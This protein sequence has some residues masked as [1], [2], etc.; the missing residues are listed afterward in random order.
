MDKY[1]HLV[2]CVFCACSMTEQIKIIITRKCVETSLPS[3]SR[4][5]FCHCSIVSKSIMNINVSVIPLLSGILD[6]V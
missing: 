5:V 1:R 4:S 2:Q 6:S 3:A